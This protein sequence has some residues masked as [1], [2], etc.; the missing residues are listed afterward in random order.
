MSRVDPCISDAL[1]RAIQQHQSGQ[2]ESARQGYERVLKVAPDNPDALH[3]SGVLAHQTGD[4]ERAVQQIRRSLDSQP[5]QPKALNNLANIFREQGDLEQA[6]EYYERATVA[7]PEYYDAYLHLGHVLWELKQTDRAGLAYQQA[8]RI[9]A[10]DAIVATRLGITLEAAGRW[11]DALTAYRESLASDGDHVL[12][13]RRLSR[14]LR[15]MDRVD[16]AREIYDQWLRIAPD[17]PLAQHFRAAC[18]EGVGPARASDDYVRSVYEDFADEFE[19]H[20]KELDYHVPEMITEAVAEIVAG[21]S[22]TK[23]DTLGV[24]DVLDI[25]DIGC[26]TGL[27]AVGLRRFAHRLDGVD[28]S[29]AMIAKARQ[30]NLYD[31][32]HESELTAYLE[33][34]TAQYDALVAADTFVYIGN[35]APVFRAAA[36]TLRPGGALVFSVE[37]AEEGDSASDFR[38]HRFGRYIHSAAYV[39]RLCQESGFALS[40]LRDVTLRTECGQ[41]VA[42]LLVVAVLPDAADA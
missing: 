10:V 28:L 35:L 8:R 5:N 22:A 17:D 7:E 41:P 14:L 33:G 39:R 37:R 6:A 15:I 1:A 3:L 34:C 26:G 30:R 16:Q 38:L 12:A 36:T 2:L 27:C 40:V 4:S 13:Y 24:L 32:L 20:L 9:G 25:L 42:G 23:P 19:E 18:D 11:E 31:A 29:P 21:R